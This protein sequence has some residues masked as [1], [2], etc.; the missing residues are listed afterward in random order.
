[1]PVVV[2]AAS[3]LN[4]GTRKGT[5]E[6]NRRKYALLYMLS[7]PGLTTVFNRAKFKVDPAKNETIE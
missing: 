7:I 1:M 5:E 2:H 6:H 4:I 3:T